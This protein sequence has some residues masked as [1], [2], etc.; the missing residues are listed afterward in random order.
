M[1]IDRYRLFRESEY[2]IRHVGD[3]AKSICVHPI[4]D[5][6]TVRMIADRCPSIESIS[7][8]E[9]VRIS[10]AS[11]L[12]LIH[13]CKHLKLIDLTFCSAVSA[14]MIKEMGQSCPN[15][16]GLNL[17]R[18]QVTEE[19]ARKMGKF[20]RKLKWL[21]LNNAT[22]SSRDVCN[23]LDSCNELHHVSLRWCHQ[24]I[25]NDELHN[26]VSSIAE[27]VYSPLPICRVPSPELS[28]YPIFYPTN[29]FPVE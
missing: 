14:S 16:V 20:M 26:R 5:D 4:A 9:C 24:L 17:G 25:M 12:Y 11:L 1:P 19:M 13:A 2:M 21:N 22:I 29:L 18:L 15:L 7:L 6:T 10:P 28:R 27:F 3:R 23:I 8:R